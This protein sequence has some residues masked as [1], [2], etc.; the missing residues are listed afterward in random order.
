MKAFLLHISP[1]ENTEQGYLK[2]P[3]KYTAF[4]HP[5]IFTTT[6]ITT[7]IPQRPWLMPAVDYGGQGWLVTKEWDTNHFI[8]EASL[9]GAIV[10]RY[11]G[12]WWG[13]RWKK[14][15]MIYLQVILCGVRK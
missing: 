10:L 9:M 3:C 1:L 7:T 12:R 4:S 2:S 15:I 13:T 14:S 6:S 5:E 8:P 11:L